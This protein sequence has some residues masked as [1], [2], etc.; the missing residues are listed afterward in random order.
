M[1]KAL[2]LKKLLKTL[3]NLALSAFI[4]VWSAGMFMGGFYGIAAVAFGIPAVVCFN[5]F[6]I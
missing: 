6:D 5:A 2:N 3:K 1:K 4:I